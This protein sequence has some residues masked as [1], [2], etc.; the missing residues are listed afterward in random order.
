MDAAKGGM[1]NADRCRENV[2]AGNDFN[3][4]TQILKVLMGNGLR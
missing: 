4:K 2:I 3:K 1:E